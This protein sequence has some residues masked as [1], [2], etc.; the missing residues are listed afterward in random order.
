M[1]TYSY[2]CR[3]CAHE[4]EQYQKFSDEPLTDC[5]TCAGTVRRVIHPVGV[6]FKGSGWYI[7]DSRSTSST[8][9]KP[10][11]KSESADKPEAAAEKS[12]GKAE[13]SG[14]VEKPAASSKAE[15]KSPAT[16]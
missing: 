4:F 9:G 10:A 8:N 2:R 6:V 12:N 5:P 16:V 1:P 3:D 11:A 7:T 15:S 13:G 14:G